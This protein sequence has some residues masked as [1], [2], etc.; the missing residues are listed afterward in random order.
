MEKSNT[1][2]WQNMSANPKNANAPDE[3][4]WYIDSLKSSDSS[5]IAPDNHTAPQN[6]RSLTPKNGSRSPQR[7]PKNLIWLVVAILILLGLVSL[8]AKRGYD[9]RLT[10]LEQEQQSQRV[11]SEEQ[12][13][14]LRNALNRITVDSTPAGGSVVVGDGDVSSSGSG[15]QSSST[16]KPASSSTGSALQGPRG[17]A[18]Q[19]GAIGPTG[20]NGANGTAGAT[21]SQGPQGP[22]GVAACP[23]GNCLSLQNSSPGTQESGSINISG[24]AN[25]GGDVH[26][27]S[28]SGDGSGLTDVDSATLNGQSESYYRNAGNLNTGTLSDSRLSGNVTV[29]G[30][31]FNGASQLVQLTAGGLLPALDG[32]NLQNVNASMLGGQSASYYTN[33][34]NISSGTLND[35]R[36]SSNVVLKDATN[37]FTGTNNFGGLTATGILQNGYQV[38]DASNNC[39]YATSAQFANAI[40]QSGNSFGTTMTI[41][42]ND[43]QALDLKANNTIGFRVFANGNVSTGTTLSLA[44]LAVVNDNSDHIALV[45]Q[46]A[47]S[48][49]VNLQEWRNASGTVLTSVKSNGDINIGASATANNSPSNSLTFEAINSS[50]STVSAGSIQGIYSVPFG[51]SQTNYTSNMHNFSGSIGQ[52]GGNISSRGSLTLQNS[53]TLNS[54]VILGGGSVTSF[55]STDGASNIGS[56]IQGFAGQT[57]NL[58]EWRNSGGTMLAQVTAGGRIQGVNTLYLDNT[59]GTST[60]AV[61]ANSVQFQ[62]AGNAFFHAS[63]ITGN[64]GIGPALTNPGAKLHVKSGGASVIAS[65]VQG[66]ASQSADL[67]Q[68]QSS[69]G[70]V[71]AKVD[72]TG[73]LTIKNAEVQGTLTVADSVTLSGNFITF[74]N[75]VRGYNVSVADTETTLDVTF[76]TAHSNASYAVMC[77]PN[78]NT[79]CFVSN[80]TTAGFTLNFG[81]AAGPSSLADWLVVR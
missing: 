77:T 27:D 39:T 6:H 40:L 65:I 2:P 57:A 32:A 41:G 81:T 60:I 55:V 34:S 79:T 47:A 59:S 3:L 25:F 19:A 38:C 80:K 1:P 46:G 14:S 13:Q 29:A 44:Q 74:S 24:T 10:N 71:L 15:V 36:L 31:S 63:G 42:T 53:A 70:T 43:N 21:G 62:V 5:D 45:V 30:N 4:A 12:N 37:T 48:Q 76:G 61:G 54:K 73:N 49:S 52:T 69:S 50:G 17:P 16:Q 66:A 20:A 9:S 67:L 11:E 33:A 22:S 28:F 26:A 23:N 35:V 51:Q 64:V 8:V 56:I 75:N 18:G 78:W 7:K 72:A 58:Q 68:L